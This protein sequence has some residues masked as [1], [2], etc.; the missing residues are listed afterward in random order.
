ME[1][2]GLTAS[3]IKV[4]A[5]ICMFLD[6]FAASVYQGLILSDRL[7]SGICF[8]D[9]FFI[10]NKPMGTPEGILYIIMRMIGR[11]S[12]PIYCF[13]IVE[14]FRHTSSKLKYLLR[15]LIF[16]AISEVPFDYAI[17]GTVF[18]P[19]YQNVFVTLAIGLA[20]LWGIDELSK[21]ELPN[22]A[23]VF[24]HI[25]ACIMSAF[26]L[27]GL[28]MR[29]CL[30]FLDSQIS[31]L[32]DAERQHRINTLFVSLWIMIAIIVLVILIVCRMKRG[33][34]RATKMSIVFA[35]AGT[36]CFLAD[37]SDILGSM[38][39]YGAMGIITILIIYYLYH[40]RERKNTS[41]VWA[42]AFMAVSQVSEIPTFACV[43]LIRAYNGQR[44]SVNKFVYYIFYPAHLLLLGLVM[45]IIGIT[46][47]G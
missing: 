12:F 24:I 37:Q 45:F 10:F 7:S 39:D 11:I 8:Y 43:P 38:S 34:E 46:P 4:I 13:F 33:E 17:F 1:K 6:H 15:L 3:S 2:K 42:C 26:I 27:A 19:L 22:V 25:G 36:A 40:V 23:I 14:G 28:M 20:M 41:I 44:G 5:M 32:P 47:Y 35:V 30:S 29:Q 31:S 21:R 9:S 18:Y 16:A